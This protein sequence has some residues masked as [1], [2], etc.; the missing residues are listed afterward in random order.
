MHRLK[1]FI[2]VATSDTGS[3]TKHV[4]DLQLGTVVHSSDRHHLLHLDCTSC[5]YRVFVVIA[6]DNMRR[7]Q[8]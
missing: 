4:C 3:H 2:E 6:Y 8:Y 1:L 5:C 7:P